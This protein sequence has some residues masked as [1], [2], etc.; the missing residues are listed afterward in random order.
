MNSQD[1]ELT[2]EEIIELQEKIQDFLGSGG[3]E[4]ENEMIKALEK[5][6]LDLNIKQI[7]AILFLKTFNNKYLNKLIE[8]YLEYKKYNRT[9]SI[10]LKGIELI[11]LYNFFKGRLRF[12]INLSK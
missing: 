1:L 12:N 3:Y 4:V 5:K 10:I 9:Y 11:S 8:D 6:S 7:K 2:K